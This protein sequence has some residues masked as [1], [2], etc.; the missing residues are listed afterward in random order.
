MQQEVQIELNYLHELGKSRDTKL[1]LL[2]RHQ[3]DIPAG[4]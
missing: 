2:L 1:T 4:I 3:K